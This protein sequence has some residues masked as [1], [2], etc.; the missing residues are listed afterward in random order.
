M[1]AFEHAY[2][3][4]AL[5]STNDESR[6]DGGDPLEDNYEI[7]DFAPACL[8]TMLADCRRFQAENA[9]TLAMEFDA[10][11]ENTFPVLRDRMAS[12]GYDFW[13]TR[14]G[15]GCGFWETDRWPEDMGKKLYETC[16]AFGP[17]DLYVG[18]DGQIYC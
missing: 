15:H 6:D 5:W 3:I 16:K 8:E 7:D 10:Y 2:L 11:V 18:D 9:K 4:C 1:N 14:N 13:L 12:A 17:V